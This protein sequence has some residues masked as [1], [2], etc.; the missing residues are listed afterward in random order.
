MWWNFR[1]QVLFEI[2]RTAVKRTDFLGRN[3]SITII[4]WRA[5]ANTSRDSI[6]MRVRIILHLI[7]SVLFGL[8]DIDWN[9]QFKNGIFWVYLWNFFV[10]VSLRLWFEDMIITIG[11]FEFVGMMKVCDFDLRG[12][13]LV[14]LIEFGSKTGFPVLVVVFDTNK[15]IA[16]LEI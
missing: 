5:G 3:L 16:I 1:T 2:W 8:A 13:K 15:V 9:F 12:K 14:G 6:L 10:G 7:G 4:F 11:L